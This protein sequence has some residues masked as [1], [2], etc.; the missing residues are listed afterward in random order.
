MPPKT[1]DSDSSKNRY[2]Y[3]HSSTIHEY[4]KVEITQLSVKNEWRNKWWLV[5]TYNEITFSH[6]VRKYNDKNIPFTEATKIIQYLEPNT[7][8]IQNLT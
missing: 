2:T 3:V 8:E 7:A 5:Y 6:K 1:E 4:Q